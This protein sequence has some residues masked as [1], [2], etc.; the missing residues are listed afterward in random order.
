LRKTWV[1]M[2]GP[3]STA[4]HDLDFRVGGGERMT[5]TFVHLSTADGVDDV[6]D[7]LSGTRLRLNGPVGAAAAA[8]AATA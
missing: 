8:A 5:N 1:R 6:K 7:L 3:S 2:P 4:T